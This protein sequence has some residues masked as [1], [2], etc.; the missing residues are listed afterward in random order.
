VNS[1][2]PTRIPSAMTMTL[3]A[4]VD[5]RRGHERGEVAVAGSKLTIS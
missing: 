5:H 1:R 2:P 3:S 4:V